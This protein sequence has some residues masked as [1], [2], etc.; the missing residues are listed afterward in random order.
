MTGSVSRNFKSNKLVR[1]ALTGNALGKVTRKTAPDDKVFS[2]RLPKGKT[3][4]YPL[5]PEFRRANLLLA[6]L[7]NKRRAGREINARRS[8][9]NKLARAL[10]GKRSA[11]DV[12]LSTAAHMPLN[13]SMSTRRNPAVASHIARKAAEV[14]KAGEMMYRLEN[15]KSRLAGPGG[16]KVK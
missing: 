16:K 2:T 9:A 10:I 13:T 5:A 15:I 3:P 14:A 7:E 1:L 4:S 6:R 12:K 11:T 8:P